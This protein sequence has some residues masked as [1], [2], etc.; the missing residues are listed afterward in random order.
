VDFYWRTFIWGDYVSVDASVNPCII[1][2]RSL[3][4]ERTVGTP[5]LTPSC[6][7]VHVADG[8]AAMSGAAM[9]DVLQRLFESE[10]FDVWMCGVFAPKIKYLLQWFS[11]QVITTGNCCFSK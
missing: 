10:F 2:S 1:V 6:P 8:T 5:P 3:C 7:A 4:A 9:T 11:F